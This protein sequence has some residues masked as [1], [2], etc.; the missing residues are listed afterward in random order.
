[1][2]YKVTLNQ[3]TGKEYYFSTKEKARSFADYWNIISIFK[4]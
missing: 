3:R 2:K 4:F 1:M